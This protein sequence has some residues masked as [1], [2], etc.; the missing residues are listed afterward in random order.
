MPCK[1]YQVLDSD[2]GNLGAQWV[3]IDE[4]GRCLNALGIV[5]NEPEN[6]EIS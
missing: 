6:K 4:N 2:G 1:R 5:M 3:I